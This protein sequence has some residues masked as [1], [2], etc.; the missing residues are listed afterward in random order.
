MIFL[1]PHSV[2]LHPPNWM[3]RPIH[4]INQSPIVTKVNNRCRTW[5]GVG[6]N[7]TTRFVQSLQNPLLFSS[8]INSLLLSKR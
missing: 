1:D 3:V 4:T 2:H 7:T 5:L 8:P 6:R